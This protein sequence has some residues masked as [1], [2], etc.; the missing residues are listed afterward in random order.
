MNDKCINIKF[1]FVNE[2]NSIIFLQNYVDGSKLLHEIANKPLV[3][4]HTHNIVDQPDAIESFNDLVDK[5]ATDFNVTPIKS[6][7]NY[8]E[9]NSTKQYHK[10]FYKQDF[11]IVFNL[12]PGRILFKEDTTGTVLDFHIEPNTLYI[13]D[14][15]INEHWMHSV[16][17]GDNDRISIV[18]W[19]IRK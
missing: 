8:F 15:L 13:F 9:K 6:R 18:V 19:G 1:R 11:T 7:I 2:M 10:D 4:W 3:K 14:K 16:E 12:D 5:I 17:M